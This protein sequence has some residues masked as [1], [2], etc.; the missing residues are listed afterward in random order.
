[1]HGRLDEIELASTVLETNA[2]G[3]AT[4]RMLYVY[5][6]PMQAQQRLPLLMVLAGYGGTNRTML[7]YSPWEP[8]VV[9]RFDAMVA[10]GRCKP[11]ILVLPDAMT[12]LG[13][14]QYLDSTATG[15]YQTYLADE[16]V[17]FVDSRYPTL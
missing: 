17:R 16:V 2:L 9:E 14:S 11:A 3:D 10:D 6:P 4:R 12:R 5:V 15:P 8:N 13:G 7:N 1:M